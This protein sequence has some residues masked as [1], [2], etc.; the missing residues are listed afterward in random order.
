MV[1]RVG[2]NKLVKCVCWIGVI[3]PLGITAGHITEKF[4]WLKGCSYMK[5]LRTGEAERDAIWDKVTVSVILQ[6][7][8][9]FV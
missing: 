3:L 5:N 1:L 6:G 8:Q 4:V 7:V 9:K 2:A